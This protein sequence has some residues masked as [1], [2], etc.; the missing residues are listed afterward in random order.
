MSGSSPLPSTVTVRRRSTSLNSINSDKSDSPQNSKPNSRTSS[1]VNLGDEP[2]T[3][4]DKT[5]NW[6]NKA[7]FASLVLCANPKNPDVYKLYQEMKDISK[8]ASAHQELPQEDVQYAVSSADVELGV[9]E[10][11]SQEVDQPWGEW[12]KEN[13]KT[14]IIAGVLLLALVIGLAVGLSQDN[15]GGSSEASAPNPDNPD[16]PDNQSDYTNVPTAYSTF[17]PTYG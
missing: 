12:I 4:Q 16:N 5:L 15:S 17:P 1:P 9:E 13:K 8:R 2:D 7:Y 14:L 6:K 10:P 11:K 3:S